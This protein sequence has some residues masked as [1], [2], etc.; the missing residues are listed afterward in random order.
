MFIEVYPTAQSV[1]DLNGK[2][3][4]VIDVLRATSVITTALHNGAERVIPVPSVEDAFRLARDLKGNSLLG[5]ERRALKIPGFDLG[6]SPLEYK[7]E[8][9]EGKTVILTT[10]NGTKA[11]KASESAEHILIGCFL[12]ASAAAGKA[13]QTLSSETTGVAVLCAGTLG[14]FSL[15][16]AA[17]AGLIVDILVRNIKRINEIPELSDLAFACRDLYLEHRHDLKTFISHAAHYK[18]LLDLGLEKD[19]DYC[20]QQDVLDCVPVYE[21]KN[22]AVKIY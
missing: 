14:E 20:L 9:V 18:R 12:N 10:S 16:D 11:I 15:D 8:L 1:K 7:K 4:I 22:M 13:L 2:T 19:I 21:K 5:G 6:N 3:A 17:C